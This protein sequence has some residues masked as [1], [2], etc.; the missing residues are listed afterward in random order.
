MSN[1]S[2]EMPARVAWNVLDIPAEKAMKSTNEIAK[3]LFLN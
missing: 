3:I 2:S 1:G